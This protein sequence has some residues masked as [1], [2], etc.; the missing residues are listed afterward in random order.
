M[1]DFISVA[2]ITDVPSGEG[3]VVEAGDVPIALFN[4]DGTFLALDN[5][6]LHRGGPLG[7]TFVRS[8]GCQATTVLSANTGKIISLR[9]TVFVF[10]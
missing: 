5:T 3:R 6:C 7:A 2:K 8:G 10:L 4:V 9:I 1:A